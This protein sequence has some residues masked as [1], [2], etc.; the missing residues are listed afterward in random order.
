MSAR[1][2]LRSGRPSLMVLGG[3]LLVFKT[4]DSKGNQGYMSRACK[5][6]WHSRPQPGSLDGEQHCAWSGSMSDDFEDHCWKDVISP[7][8]LEVYS[9]YQRKTFV[10][11]DP[12]LLAID[13]YEAVYRGG[14]HPPH[15]LAKTHPVACGHY[16]YEAIE[17]TKRLFAAARAA[18]LPIFYSTGDTSAAGRPALGA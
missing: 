2:F 7:E 5:A 15:E 11:P 9:C 14:A 3:R 4:A 18:G 17:P 6:I 1:T 8:D 13:L 16:A 10:G 12:A